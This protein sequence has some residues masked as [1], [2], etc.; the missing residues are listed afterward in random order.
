M[1]KKASIYMTDK[2]LDAI[3]DRNR[4]GVVNQTIQRLTVAIDEVE[5]TDNDRK[6]YE[7]NRRK[8]NQNVPRHFRHYSAPRSARRFSYAA[9]SLFS[10][11]SNAHVNNSLVAWY[12]GFR[13]RLAQSATRVRTSKYISTWTRPALSS[14]IPLPQIV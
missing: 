10:A 1:S 9:R 11:S 6:F 4:G 7:Q 8:R 13:F 3:G 12:C 2:T 5:I 14:L